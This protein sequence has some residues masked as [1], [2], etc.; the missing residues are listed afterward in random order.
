MIDEPERGGGW[1]P[2]AAAPLAGLALSRHDHY[3]RDDIARRQR[4]QQHAAALDAQWRAEDAAPGGIGHAMLRMTGADPDIIFAKL[5]SY[6]TDHSWVQRR[7]RAALALSA[8]DPFAMPPLRMFSGGALGG[9]ILAEVPPITLSLMI[10]PFNQPTPRDPSV[11]FS[12]GHGLTQIVR[13]GG[14]CIRRY[15]VRLSDEERAGKFRSATAAPLEVLG[16]APLGDGDQIR[17]DQQCESFNLTPG[18]GDLV[19]LQLFVH[20][21]SRVPMREY[22]PTTGRLI[23]AAAA[24]RATSFR[25]MGLAVLRAF[26]RSDAAPLFA[27]ALNDDDFAMRWQVMR[28]LV[29]LDPQAALP[30]LGTMAADDPHPEVRAAAQATLAILRERTA[31]TLVAEP[32]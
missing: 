13:S 11:I 7:L 8:A 2:L 31:R 6:L 12:P 1:P 22:D 27:A 30:P 18:D 29:A 24:G 32:A 26:G 5:S 21:A 17:V 15:R 19:M 16:T 10:R 28:E 3:P 20:A 9:L 23:R 25:Q 4:M 14:A